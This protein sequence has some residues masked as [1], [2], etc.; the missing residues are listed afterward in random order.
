MNFEWD[1]LKD[2]ANQRKH[3]ISFTE[4]ITVFADPP[5]KI[6]EDPDHSQEEI[7][8]IIIG[9]SEERRLLLVCFTERDDRVRITSAR[10][11]TKDERQ[12]YEESEPED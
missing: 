9:H 8:E 5:A 11:T 12:N 3:G 6:F 2:R 1:R 7:R 4:A 10:E